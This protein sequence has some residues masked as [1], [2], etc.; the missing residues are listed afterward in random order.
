MEFLTVNGASVDI[1]QALQWQQIAGNTDF[2]DIT[3]TS[4]A[5]GGSR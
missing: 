1:K 2:T 4:A 5:S 3:I